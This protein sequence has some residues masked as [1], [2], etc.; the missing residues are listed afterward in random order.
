M[1]FEQRREQMPEY[2]YPIQMIANILGYI[3]PLNTIRG[4][5]CFLMIFIC[6]RLV[7]KIIGIAIADLLGLDSGDIMKQRIIAKREQKSIDAKKLLDN[8]YKN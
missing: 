1:S 8:L 2:S 6:I 4:A 5:V 3:P 7:F